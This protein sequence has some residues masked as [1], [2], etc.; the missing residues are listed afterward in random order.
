MNWIVIA[1][2]IAL[3]VAFATTP[4]VRRIAI[5]L[6]VLVHPGGRRVHT[7]P[8]PMWGG[9]A[10]FG[11]FA[12][13]VLLLMTF[14][15]HKPGAMMPIF[16]VIVSGML[17]LTFGMIDDMK[18]LSAPVQTV[19]IVASAIVLMS[20]GVRIQILT[21][22]FGHPAMIPI[23]GAL[24]WGL[25]LAWIFTITKT[26]DF[27]DGLDGLAAGIGAIASGVLAIMANH[28]GQTNVALMA[29]ALCGACVG[30]L[31]FNFNPAKIFMGTGG[32][33][34]IGFS[35]AAISIVGAFKMTAAIAI[36]LPMLVFGV[37][38]FD[39][40]YVVVKRLTK[41]QPVSKAD[42]SH[43]HHRLLDRGLTHRQAV[44]V[45]WTIM[46]IL[47]FAALALLWHSKVR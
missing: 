32:S 23:H 19:L 27:M 30:F 20:F 36:A 28:S 46:I 1:F 6:N 35:L 14:A 25:T 13:A 31:R 10:I 43:L 17:I 34:F 26:I 37:P 16:G 33:Q 42:K 3:I 44:I 11:A 2:F 15:V 40:F 47:G 38:I 41:G 21:N 9:L 29:G 22:P 5:R 8:M 4:S 12:V 7:R 39:G 45:I 24:S 18:E